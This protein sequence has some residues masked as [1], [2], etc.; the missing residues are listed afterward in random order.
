MKH[1][2][3]LV[4]KNNI[5]TLKQEFVNHVI[6]N[7]KIVLVKQLQCVLNV[8]LE[9]IWKPIL[10]NHVKKNARLV[11]LELNVK[12][13]KTIM[14]NLR[15]SKMPKENVFVLL[16][17]KKS[18]EHCNVKRF[19]KRLVNMKLKVN[20][21]HVVSVIILAKNVQDQIKMNVA[22]VKKLILEKFKVHLVFHSQ[23]ILKNQTNQFVNHVQALVKLVK[24][25][26]NVMNVMKHN[27]KIQSQNYVFVK[28]K[29]NTKL[30]TSLVVHVI[31]IAKNVL[32]IKKLIAKNVMQPNIENSMKKKIHVNVK[33]N[34]M[35]K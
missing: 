7:V 8:K 11:K 10:A 28:K 29:V 12:P 21:I 1:V 5:E 23:D 3:H 13:V 31:V 4:L 18:Q 26:L 34:L 15:E 35:L 22:I 33:L 6:L 16:V 30:M 27:I 14:V 2:K 32:E 20:M 9:N 25:Q 19:V 24:K 17:I